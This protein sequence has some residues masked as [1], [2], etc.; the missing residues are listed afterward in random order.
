VIALRE[1]H[2]RL[3]A[4]KAKFTAD[5][6]KMFE[7]SELHLEPNAKNR[8]AQKKSW[9]RWRD[10]QDATVGESWA[11]QHEAEKE[12]NACQMAVAKV[13]PRDENDLV[14]KAAVASVYDKV[15]GAHGLNVAVIS[16]SVAFDFF[17]MRRP[18]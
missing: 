6:M 18:V 14:L 2:E 16:Y 5:D 3:E 15:K 13:K 11:A 10:M 9:R 8:R 7:W 1:S 4:A 12:F 17:Q